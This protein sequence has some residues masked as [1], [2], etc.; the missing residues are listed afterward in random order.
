MQDPE[1]S[2]LDAQKKPDDW[3]VALL[4]LMVEVD[5]M[6]PP[7]EHEMNALLATNVLEMQVAL[8]QALDP[9]AEPQ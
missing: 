2:K 1:Q 3:L 5:R 9:E 6:I 8:E 7:P 4:E